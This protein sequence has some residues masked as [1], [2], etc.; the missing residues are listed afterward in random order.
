MVRLTELQGEDWCK[1]VSGKVLVA[2]KNHHLLGFAG[3]FLAQRRKDAKIGL[4]FFFASLRL[5]GRKSIRPNY[6]FQ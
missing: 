2:I 1:Y 4:E 5:C 6:D 3:G